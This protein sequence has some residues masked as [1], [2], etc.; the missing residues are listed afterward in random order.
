MRLPSR[1]GAYGAPSSA[2]VP[3]D[4]ASTPASSLNKVVLPAP[5]DPTRRYAPGA[6]RRLAL[7]KISAPPGYAKE[8]LSIAIV[9]AAQGLR[10]PTAAARSQANAVSP[11]HAC[12]DQPGGASR[13]L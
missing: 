6:S 5:F 2:I 9:G 4:G 11:L 3:D 13:R 10:W 7:R 8:R 1:H 12:V